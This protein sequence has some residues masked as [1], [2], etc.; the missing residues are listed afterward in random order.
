MS[1]HTFIRQ[2]TSACNDTKMLENMQCLQSI[3][4]VNLARWNGTVSLEVMKSQAFTLESTIYMRNNIC[5][6]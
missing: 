1:D 3:N 6:S 5:M 4:P 2:D